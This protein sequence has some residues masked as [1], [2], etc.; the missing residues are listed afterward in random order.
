MYK[1]LASGIG[2]VIL[3]IGGT[4]SAEAYAGHEQGDSV[5]SAVQK[6][7]PDTRITRVEPHGRP[8]IVA[9][10]GGSE[11]SSAYVD[12]DGTNGRS[13]VIVEN[14]NRDT[15][16]VSSLLWFPHVPQPTSLDPVTTSDGAYTA[17]G[18]ATVDGQKVTVT[19]TA[20]LTGDVLSVRPSQVVP[21]QPTGSAQPTGSKDA[22]PTDWAK[23]LTPAPV[24]LPS[25]VH[26]SVRAVSV[27]PN[28]ISVE[29]RTRD[30]G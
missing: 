5:R 17:S 6:L 23:A 21:S 28:D 16:T 14:L 22:V 20:T 1:Q 27:R 4:V 29:L 24:R 30:A 8:F 2:A 3:L 19:F 7:F 9:R 13:T 10:L 26:F 25:T 18:K 11:V 15:G 12:I